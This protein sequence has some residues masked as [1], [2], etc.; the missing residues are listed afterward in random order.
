MSEALRAVPTDG[1]MFAVDYQATVQSVLDD[2]EHTSPVQLA[3]QVCGVNDM[4]N[5][6]T[7]SL[8]MAQKYIGDVF[9]EVYAFRS[10]IR[11]GE[12]ANARNLAAI[13]TK[14]LRQLRNRT[15]D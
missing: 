5:K 2:R 1:K 14:R 12:H 8:I 11:Q 9:D 10:E 4:D 3:M 7:F 13:L 15:N 6:R